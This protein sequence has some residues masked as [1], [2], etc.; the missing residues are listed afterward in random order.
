MAQVV[1]RPDCR[2]LS[3]QRAAVGAVQSLGFGRTGVAVFRAMALGV[4]RDGLTWRSLETIARE[5][6]M[7]VGKHPETTL[8]NLRRRYLR[9]LERAGAIS[10]YRQGVG[11]GRRTVWIIHNLAEKGGHGDPLL[12]RKGGHGDSRKGGHGDPLEEER[13]YEEGAAS[14]FP[15]DD[16]PYGTPVPMP[17][18][19]RSAVGGPLAP[20]AADQLDLLGAEP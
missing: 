6:G 13:N 5:A 10:I 20:L 12:T 9:P 3:W 11:R 7:N 15:V 4:D 17:G 2:N 1:E 8:R 16:V 19:V 18:W 14:L